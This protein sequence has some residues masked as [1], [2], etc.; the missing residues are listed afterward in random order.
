MARERRTVA[1]N[2]RL[3]PTEAEQIDAWRI[4]ARPAMG[5]G[6]YLRRRIFSRASVIP[7]LAARL[8]ALL[9]DVRDVKNRVG[10]ERDD[11]AAIE[12]A[13]D[14]LYREA[15]AESSTPGLR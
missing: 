5:R 6:N 11:I 12:R 4:G 13:L 14:H 7:G 10:R 2:L 9:V 1:V 3:T 8:R 15:L